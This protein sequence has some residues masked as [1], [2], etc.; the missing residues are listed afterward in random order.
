MP[1]LPEVEVVRRGLDDHVV[2]RTIVSVDV[3]DTRS[4]RRHG[5]GPHDFIARLRGQQVR[6][7][8]RRG[9]YLWLPLDDGDAL[10]A[11]LG[12]S[13]QMLISAPDVPEPRHLRVRVCLDDGN[14]LRFV[15][16]RIFGGLAVSTGGAELPDEIEHIARDP[17]DPLFDAAEFSRRLRRR[18]TGIKRALLDQ[19]LV[20]GVGNIY[21]DEA[22]WRTP[23]HYARNTRHLRTRE[24]DG[25]LGHLRDVM[26]DALDQGGTS[27]DALYVNIN[28]QSG[29]FDRS[30]HAYGREG[31]PCD[32]CGT[33]MRRDSFM[34]RSSYWCPR[35]Q[36]RPRNGRW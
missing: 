20:S 27:F 19:T 2:G 14:E 30:L 1:E 11:H 21:A 31:E 26:G 17:L 4:V 12:M 18:E 35:C 7:A 13:G 15:D 34:N 6:A 36:P 25:L 5:P 3:L 33:P 23:L 9:K 16:Q 28:G 10:L 29:Y 24:I 8:R 32:R 22:L